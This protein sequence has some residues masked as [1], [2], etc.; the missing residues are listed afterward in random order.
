MYFAIILHFNSKPFI[1]NEIKIG[2]CPKMSFHQSNFWRG[3]AVLRVSSGKLEAS[4]KTV[5]IYGSYFYHLILL[6]TCEQSTLFTIVYFLWNNKFLWNRTNFDQF[7][8]GYDRNRIAE[9]DRFL[10]R[11]FEIFFLCL[12]FQKNSFFWSIIHSWLVAI[13]YDGY[14]TVLWMAAIDK[15]ND[16]HYH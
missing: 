12:D 7:S 1:I 9:S 11:P 10:K 14:T 2:M 15:N 6:L 4:C 16:I 5:Y 13:R 3:D 8:T